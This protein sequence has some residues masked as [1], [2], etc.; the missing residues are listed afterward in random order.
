MNVC[1]FCGGSNLARA[2][3]LESAEQMAQTLVGRRHTLIYGGGGIGLMGRL[4]DAALALGGEVIGVMPTSLIARELAHPGLS[5][6]IVVP[7]ML[8]RKKRMAELSGAF[9]ALPGGY[10]TLDELFEMLTWTQMGTQHKPCGML[11]IAGF[12]NLLLAWVDHAVLE[13]LIHPSHRGLLLEHTDA[14][15]LLDQLESWTLPEMPSLS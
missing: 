1:V 6:L 10:G 14:D 15:A 9:V 7:D 3:Y 2:P 12:Y 11:N 5:Q 8:E 4:A 13:G